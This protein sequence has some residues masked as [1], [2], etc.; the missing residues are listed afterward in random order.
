MRKLLI[1]MLFLSAS[2]V[3][4]KVPTPTGPLPETVQQAT[5]A[6]ELRGWGHLDWVFWDVYDAAL[7]TETGTWSYEHAFALDIRYLRKLSGDDIAVRG[8]EEM[9]EQGY[10]DPQKLDEW[11]RIQREA[12]P[13]V[14]KGDH[15]TGVYLPP[16]EVRF[17]HN[18]KLTGTVNNRAFAEAFFGIWLAPETSAP[19]LRAQLLGRGEDS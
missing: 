18:G 13:D 14:Q 2:A 15:L 6:L 5:P 7:W 12:F 17:Y 10:S 3:L 11:L 9:R 19:E 8:I 1:G 16:D 4:A